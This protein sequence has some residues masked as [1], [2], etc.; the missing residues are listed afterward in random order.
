[1]IHEGDRVLKALCSGISLLSRIPVGM[2]DLDISKK[3]YLF[4]PIGGFLGL[5]IGTL[6]YFFALVFPPEL[7]AFLILVVV[8]WVCGF[9]H[10]DGLADMGDGIMAQGNKERKISAMKDVRLGVGGMGTVVLYLIGLYAV[11]VLISANASLSM[12]AMLVGEICA[13]HSM[14]MMCAVGKPISQ[15]MG[16]LFLKNTTKKHLLLSFILSL[17]LITPLYYLGMIIPGVFAIVSSTLGSIFL[18]YIAEKNFGG[19][20]GDI[21]GASNEIGRILALIVIGGIACMHL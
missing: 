8:Y 1:L 11:L 13:K 10:L 12:I 21:I 19:V 9:N 18:L 2:E 6:A 15:G 20:N 14:V 4:V 7:S 5:I 17:F 3:T 16:A